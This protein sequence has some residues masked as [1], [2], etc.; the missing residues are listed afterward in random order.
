MEINRTKI[1]IYKNKKQ[2][3]RSQKVPKSTRNYLKKIQFKNKKY[4][5]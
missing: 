4:Y 3:F 2:F 1:F 5:K